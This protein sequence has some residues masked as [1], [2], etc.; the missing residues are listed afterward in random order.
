MAA[1]SAPSRP[2]RGRARVGHGLRQ[3]LPPPRRAARARTT[4][5]RRPRWCPP[6]A[7]A[8]FHQR[9]NLLRAELLVRFSGEPG[10]MRTVVEAN[11]RGDG[12]L[13]ASVDDIK[14]EL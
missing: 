2:R 9:T 8:A 13:Q 12:N 10:P 14:L 1:A 7:S 11:A 6:S 4:A 3:A 5:R